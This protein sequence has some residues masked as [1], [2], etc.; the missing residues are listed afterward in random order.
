MISSS[1]S[2]RSSSKID[3]VKVGEEASH[4]SHG[5]WTKTRDL[6]GKK[7]KGEEE[8]RNKGATFQVFMNFVRQ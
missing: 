6:K 7:E 4:R 3:E 1:R 8:Q 5:F 2:S